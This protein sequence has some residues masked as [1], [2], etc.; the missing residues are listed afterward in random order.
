MTCFRSHEVG[1]CQGAQADPAPVVGLT[2]W[3]LV[4]GCVRRPQPGQGGAPCWTNDLDADEDRRRIGWREDPD[5]AAELAHTHPF[6]P[7]VGSA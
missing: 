2:G 6:G 3:L 5:D 1:P 7:E 4:G